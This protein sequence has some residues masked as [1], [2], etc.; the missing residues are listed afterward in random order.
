MEPAGAFS[1]ND[2]MVKK[3]QESGEIKGPVCCTTGVHKL[4]ELSLAIGPLRTGAIL[5]DTQTYMGIKKDGKLIYGDIVGASASGKVR[6]VILQ[7]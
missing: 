5:R 7:L 3:L 6:A 1:V 2:E 4:H